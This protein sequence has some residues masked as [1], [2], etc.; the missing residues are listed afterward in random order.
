MKVLEEEKEARFLFLRR[1]LADAGR[2][3][4]V[5]VVPLYLIQTMP[6]L[7]PALLPRTSKRELS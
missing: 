4:I 6:S 5:C 3:L 2:L 1:A 7:S